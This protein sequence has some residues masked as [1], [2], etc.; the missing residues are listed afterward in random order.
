MSIHPVSKA[1]AERIRQS[2]AAA[3]DPGAL[4]GT[5]YRRLFQ[6]EPGLRSLFPAE[7]SGQQRKLAA[8]LATAVAR[9]EDGE[10]LA[11]AVENLG[12]RHQA[13]GVR[14]EHYPPVGAALLASL[15]EVSG[16]QLDAATGAAWGRAFAWL[17]AT[18]T[19]PPSR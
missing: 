18:M 13:L 6:A 19:A 15:E 10:A 2:F 11:P 1:D 14:A 8:M 17:A 4:A 7:M 9:I 5:F 3:R 16:R 12:R